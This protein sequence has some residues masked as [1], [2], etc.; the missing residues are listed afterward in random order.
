MCVLGDVAGS[1]NLST[2]VDG[3]RGICAGQLADGRN[4]AAGYSDIAAERWS[5]GTVD[6]LTIC[7]EQVKACQDRFLPNLNLFIGR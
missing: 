7:D 6:D 1:D 2:S 3:A 5:A 4:P